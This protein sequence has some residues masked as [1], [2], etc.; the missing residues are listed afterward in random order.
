MF[1]FSLSE[2][3]LEERNYN[4]S[5]SVHFIPRDSKHT[6]PDRNTEQSRYCETQLPLSSFQAEISEPDMTLF[7]S[8]EPVCYLAA[9]GSLRLL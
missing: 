8:A 6:D 9:G 4:Y 2:I 5:L 7:S 3:Y 1:F